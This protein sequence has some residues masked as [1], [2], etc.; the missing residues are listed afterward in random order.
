[1]SSWLLSVRPLQ[2]VNRAFPYVG[3]DDVDVLVEEHTP[4]LFRL[5]YLKDESHCCELMLFSLN[6]LTSGTDFHKHV[7]LDLI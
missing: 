1:M 7:L 3:A 6:H 5:V 2:G 4:I